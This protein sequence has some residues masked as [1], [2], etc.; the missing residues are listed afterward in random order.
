[1]NLEFISGLRK[2]ELVSLVGLI[3]QEGC[4]QMV[5]LGPYHL[6]DDGLHSQ[7]KIMEETAWWTLRNPDAGLQFFIKSMKEHQYFCCRIHRGQMRCSV[8]SFWAEFY[9]PVAISHVLMAMTISF[10]FSSVL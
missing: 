1:M 2:P 5:T 9:E 10:P 8:G 3:S 4:P 6:R 7:F